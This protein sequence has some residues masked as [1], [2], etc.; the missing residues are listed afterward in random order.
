MIVD[1]ILTVLATVLNILLAPLEAVNIGIDLVVSIPV[2]A[3][4]LQVVAY[5]IPWANLLPLFGIV[6]AILLLKII[7]AFVTG[8]WDL[9][10]LL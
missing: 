1:M 5:L 8:V 6:V 7:I 4:F 2:V 9:L 10:P 3:S